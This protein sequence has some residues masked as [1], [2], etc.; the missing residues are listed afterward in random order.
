MFIAWAMGESKS[1]YR[2]DITYLVS[3]FFPSVIV[4]N[5]VASILCKI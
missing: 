2:I 5:G 4:P 3:S 1:K